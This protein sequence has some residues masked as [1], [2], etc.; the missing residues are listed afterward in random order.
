MARASVKSTIPSDADHMPHANY[1]DNLQ[2]VT[3]I[4]TNLKEIVMSTN[5]SP[6]DR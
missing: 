1:H 6:L 4:G 5:T 3:E 2:A